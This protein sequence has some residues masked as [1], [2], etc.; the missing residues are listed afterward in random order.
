LGKTPIKKRFCGKD[1]SQNLFCLYG[2]HQSISQGE[3][4]I[5]KL[6]GKFLQVTLGITFSF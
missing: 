3:E 1:L 2:N 6:S 4:E 5:A